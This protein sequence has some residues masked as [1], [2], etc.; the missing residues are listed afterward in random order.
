MNIEKSFLLDP[1]STIY[2]AIYNTI[3]NAV[4]CASLT[5][6]I[7][8]IFENVEENN[9]VTVLFCKVTGVQLLNLLKRTQIL[10]FFRDYSA[11][12]QNIYL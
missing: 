4:Y 6:L 10:L 3:Y 11:M 1:L 9:F 5:L 8:I 2:C 7:L 12:L